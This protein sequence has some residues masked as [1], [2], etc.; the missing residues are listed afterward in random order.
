MSMTF[1]IAAAAPGCAIVRLP[2]AF[3]TAFNRKLCTAA[4]PILPPYHVGIRRG[5]V[6]HNRVHMPRRL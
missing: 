1:E 2:A 4:K 3:S 6:Q 5:Y